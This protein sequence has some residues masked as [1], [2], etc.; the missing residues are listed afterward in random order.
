LTFA[1]LPSGSGQALTYAPLP[2][3]Q[4]PPGQIA[5]LFLAQTGPAQI[6]KPA[7][8]PGI[9]PALAQDPAPHGTMVGDAFHITATA[10]VVAYDI[11]PYGGGVS[12]ITSATLLLPTTAWDTNYVA[13][14]AYGAD[15]SQSEG[16]W[17]FVDVVA[18][19]DGT[20]VTLSP[21]AAIVGGPG[22][23]ATSQGKPATYSLSRG[24][25]LHLTQAAE[26]AGSPIQSNNPVGVLGG[27]RCFQVPASAPACDS[28][29]Q[30]IPPVKALGSEYVAARYRDR[31]Q[32]QVESPPWRIV[33]AVDGTVLTYDPVAPPGA[34]ATLSTGQ[35]VDF[36]SAGGFVVKSQD[37]QHPFFL[38]SY[39]TGAALMD[40][41]ETDGRGDPEF[42]ALVPPQQWLGSYVFFTDPTYP[43]T[44]LVVARAKAADGTFAD[45]SLDCA[46]TLTG[47]QTVGKGD[48]Q[49]TT[50]DLVTGNFYRVGNCD[51]GRHTIQSKGLFGLTVWGWGSAATGGVVDPT[52]TQAGGLYSQYVSYGYPAGASVQAINQVVVPPVEK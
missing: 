36:E 26:L 32:G 16:S 34:P 41:S 4:L 14:D 11:F 30:Q 50:V 21:T 28:A 2:N 49:V 9:T 6:Y 42:V 13:V 1:R 7:C 20:T 46:G 31:W 23:A 38:A 35:V 25:V 22:V 33:G 15:Q 52:Q 17:P 27:S 51:N 29:H 5:I 44:N 10:P 48:Y 8:P 45:V 24:Q 19:Q 12:A 37:A 3:G 47:W 40:P 18:A 39:M 43:E